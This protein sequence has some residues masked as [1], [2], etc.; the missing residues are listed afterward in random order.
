MMA[1][2]LISALLFAGFLLN[3]RISSAW[4]LL[5]AGLVF[6]TLTWYLRQRET[7]LED[8]GRQPNGEAGANA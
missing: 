1:T 7:A 4:Q 8:V 5:G 2:R 3:E 6:V